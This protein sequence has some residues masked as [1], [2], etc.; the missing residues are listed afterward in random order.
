MHI[1]GF[2]MTNSGVGKL[3]VFC[4]LFVVLLGFSASTGSVLAGA[5]EEFEHRCVMPMETLAA[6]SLDGLT[7]SFGDKTDSLDLEFFKSEALTPADFVMINR[8]LENDQLTCGIVINGSET[9]PDDLILALVAW[10][11][12]MK[13]EGRYAVPDADESD[14]R[15]YLHLRSTTWIEPKIELE[16]YGF[17]TAFFL[18]MRETDLES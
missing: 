14:P 13:E 16:L 15:S 17:E 3:S 7:L 6:P 12:R 9:V 2:R 18:V 4:K 5:W 1:W 10:S 8:D 11:E